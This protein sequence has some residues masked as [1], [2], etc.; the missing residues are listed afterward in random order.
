MSR[1]SAA[2]LALPGCIG[3]DASLIG[4]A[5]PSWSEPTLFEPPEGVP[6]LAAEVPE[7]SL[8]DMGLSVK[9][10][11][12]RTTSLALA[13]CSLALGDRRDD[14]IGLAYASRW[15]CLASMKLFFAKVKTR[16]RVA[17]PLP[18]SHS[19]VNSTAAVAAIEF[20]LKGFHAVFSEGRKC[21]LAA[22]VA[23]AAEV[24]ETGA[25]VVVLAADALA[26]ERYAFYLEQGRIGE[27]SEEQP[28]KF[29]P[30]EGA[31]AL[32]VER[33]GKGAEVL[34]WCRPG[35]V[36]ESDLI[37]VLE[38]RLGSVPA[39]VYTD[40]STKSEAAVYEDAL[41]GREFVHLGLVLGEAEAALPLASAA[42]ASVAGEPVLCISGGASEPLAVVIRPG[43][44]A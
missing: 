34:S 36:E 43:A 13:A 35:V 37:P 38:E 31:V 2:G 14:A 1:I 26:P 44:A 7:F 11:L 29:V 9:S 21:S 42:R 22:L 23:A 17:P 3:S 4:E 27:P 19:Y 16:P 15:G 40:A 30:S 39:K 25:P 41:G 6:S 28:D 33:D 32:L 8:K 18:F 20:G 12:D 10:Y 24:E 5:G